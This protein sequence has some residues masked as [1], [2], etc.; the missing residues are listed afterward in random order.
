MH[1]VPSDA[2]M[3]SCD[4]FLE[5][6]DQIDLEIDLEAEIVPEIPDEVIHENVEVDLD[7]TEQVA[8][9]NS[10]PENMPKVNLNFTQLKVRFR[11]NIRSKSNFRY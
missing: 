8:F 7:F 3:D 1:K 5:F 6:E 11:N 4:E 10:D 9:E 2:K